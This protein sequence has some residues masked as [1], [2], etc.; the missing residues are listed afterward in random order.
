MKP[1]LGVLLLHGFT[2]NPHSLGSLELA[3]RELGLPQANPVLRGHGGASAE[4]LRGLTWHHWLADAE[5]ALR[6]L[7]L[8]AQRVIVLG[9]SMGGLAALNLAADH[10]AAIDSLILSATPIQLQSPFAPGGRLQWLEP[11]LQ[12]LLRGWPIPKHYAD[13]SLVATDTSY[14]WAP[15]DALG[16]FL[17]FTVQTR[18]RLREVTAPALILQSRSDRV[19]A[20]GS[21]ELLRQELGT[22]AAA[23]QVVWVERSG[24]ELFRDC[25]QAAAIAAAVGFVQ[26]RRRRATTLRPC[27]LS[28]GESRRM[29]TDKAL[30]P[31]PEGGTWLEHALRLLQSLGEPVTLLSRHPEH[32]ELAARLSVIAVAEPP[33]WEGPLTALGRLMD[34]HSG[35]ALLLAPV[36]MPGLRP[37]SLRALLQ[38]DPGAGSG[39]ITAHDGQREQP[40]PG[41][42]PATAANRT[43]LESY[44]SAGGRSLLGWLEQVGRSSV[45]LPAAELRNLNRPGE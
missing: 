21:V 22:A 8:R 40:L 18:G 10:P 7:R 34:L 31:H 11:A 42:Y 32:L 43:A 25:D 26:E 12:R 19:V 24:H 30:L 9:H 27:L 28:G 17:A 5:A 41:L 45:R 39:I 35:A 1:A 14:R 38:A 44:T 36:D 13:P 33:P 29:G 4:A 6:A 2:G 15:T 37:E 16:S 3:L 20:P 23:Q